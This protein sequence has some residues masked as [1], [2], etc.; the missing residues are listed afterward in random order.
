M[1][2]YGKIINYNIITTFPIEHTNVNKRM[3]TIY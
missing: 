3:I 2:T 1:C